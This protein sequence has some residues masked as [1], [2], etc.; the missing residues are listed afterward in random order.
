MLALQVTSLKNFMNALLVGDLFDI[1][2][3]EEAQIT[4]AATYTIDGRINKEFYT[5]EEWS[6]KE[7]HPFEFAAW[8]DM[9]SSCFDLIKGKRTPLNFKFVFQLM[10]IHTATILKNGNSTVTP[11]LV[12]A[13]VVTVKYDGEKVN[14]FTGTSFHTFIPDKE[15][16]KL[17]DTAFQQFLYKKGI[18]YEVI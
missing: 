1:F 8:S 15:P 16:D 14:L 7:E 18:A 4:T 9:K 2:L 12:K 13:F 3:L 10:P 5:K 17:W 6:N 11:D